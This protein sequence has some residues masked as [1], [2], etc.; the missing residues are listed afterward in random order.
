MRKIIYLFL[1]FM[2]ALS[3]TYAQQHTRA[4]FSDNDWKSLTLNIDGTSSIFLDDMN[5]DNSVTGLQARGWVVL[6][7]DGGGTVDPWNQGDTGV[8]EAYEGPA[9]GYTFTNYQGANGFLIDQWLI[10]PEITVNSG[11]TLSFWYRSPD[12]SIWDDSLYIRYSTT[13]GITPGAFDQTW[14][15]YYVPITGWTRWTGTFSNSGTIRFAI[16]YYITDGGPSGTYSNY[17]GIDYIEVISSGGG[18]AMDKLLLTEFVVTPTAGEFIEIYNP[19]ASPVDLTNYFLS[20]V[21]FDGGP[22][23][24]YHVVQGLYGGGFG[25]FNSRFPAGATIGAG[26]HQ[27]IS[28]AP[29]TDFFGEYGVNPTY[30]IDQPEFRFG[31]PDAIPD[32]LETHPG[33]IFGADSSHDPGL[34]NGDEMV[35][36]YYWDDLSDLVSDVDYVLYN[37]GSPVANNE[38]IDKTGITIDGPDPGTTGSTYLNDTPEAS[39]LSALNHSGGSSTQRVDYTE[40]A[41]VMTGGNGITGADETSEDMN[42]TWIVGVPSPFL[43]IQV[44]LT[45]FTAQVSSRVVTLYWS[46]ATEQNNQGFEIQRSTDGNFRAIGFVNGFGT[47][48]EVHNY[49]FTDN[50]V[51]V[52]TYYYRLKQVD[53]DGSFEYS[54]VI[55][56]EVG[57]PANFALEQNYPNPFNPSTK[58]AFSL[59]V[60]SKVSLKLFDV[61]GQEVTNLVT[62]NMAAGVH[63]IDFNASNLNSG[64]YFY[65]IDAAG[66]DGTNFNSIKK[67]I[68][69]K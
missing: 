27:I 51:Q 35:M 49:S 44:E 32:M 45:S 62:S 21:A 17:V 64:V 66:I 53:Y 12:A 11:D 46:T 1:T 42:N 9:N 56:A 47:T 4:P 38:F 14:G 52:G 33:S 13:A 23:Y 15:R 29:D 41:Q 60:D 20:D 65:R 37:S 63:E 40:G 48:T 19:N 3:F 26:E 16:Q 54:E 7:E 31:P 50:D 30:E 28:L 58:I 18:G 55:E 59:P 36:L 6:N 8:F 68:L 43:P 22:E 10:S 67:M 39:Q 61:L 2:V 25:D 24:Y 57:T 34:T 5:G 69:T